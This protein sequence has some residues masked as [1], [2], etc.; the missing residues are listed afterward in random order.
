MTEG[1]VCTS[2]PRVMNDNMTP[3]ALPEQGTTPFCINCG[4][5]G[6]VASDCMVPENAVTEE[7]VQAAW[8]APVT[9]S[10]DF[11]N[12][13]NQIRV[14]STSEEGGPHVLWL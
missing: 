1:W 12:T 4:R 14:I 6:H 3:A 13:D 8:Y 9:S 5:A 7:Q 11:A 2:N 10:A